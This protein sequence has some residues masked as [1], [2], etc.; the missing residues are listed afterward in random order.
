MLKKIT[1]KNFRKHTDSVFEFDDGL[2][3]MRGANEAGKSTVLEGVAYALGGVK[4]LRS[5]LAEAVTWSQP[6]NTLK[7]VLEIS[8]DGVD[9]VVSRGKSGAE[10]NYDGGCVTG[11]TEVTNFLA[12]K[13]KV[14][15]GA[16]SRLMMSSQMDIRG[17]LEA[18]PKATT[19]LIER[20]AEFDQ[21]DHLIDVMQEKLTLGSTATA[22]AQLASA[23]ETLDTANAV[24]EPDFKGL[25]QRI[26][27]AT[28]N[29]GLA[30]SYYDDAN[31]AY[32]AALKADT[33]ARSAV[34]ER[35]AAA[36]RL[37]DAEALAERSKAESIALS[38]ATVT[39]PLNP[40]ENIQA[41]MQE[42]ANLAL[43][44]TRR[45]AWKE[46]QPF[47]GS[48]GVTRYP[49]SAEMLESSIKGAQR[50]IDEARDAL[51]KGDVMHA[52]LTA[53]LMLNSCSFCGKDFS[54]V[55]EVQAKNAEVHAAIEANELKL[56]AAQRT[57]DDCTAALKDLNKV[58]TEGRGLYAAAQRYAPYLDI[59]DSV[60]P[61][62]LSWNGE[63]PTDNGDV[64]PDY[65]AMIASI[66]AQVKAFA[67]WE[68]ARE[69]VEAESA[70]ARLGIDQA[71]A[72]LDALPEADPS[73][74]GDALGEANK[75][76]RE[77]S[78]TRDEY[79]DSLRAAKNAQDRAVLD[80]E[81]TQM[82]IASAD[83]QL[84]NARAAL[85]ALT[86]NNALLKKVRTARPVIAD[87]LWNLV[88]TSVSKYFS[89]M[90]GVRS[91]VSKSSDGF[92]VD[93]RPVAVLSG[94]T[95]DI[96][97]LAIRVALVRTFLPQS[98]FLVLDEPMAGCDLTR[99][100]AMLGFLVAVGF[101]QV[102][103]VTHEDVS[104]SV[105]DHIITLGE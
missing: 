40:D 37:K 83:A 29:L 92:L 55:P 33:E 70:R 57:S 9:Y 12:A 23:Q 77:A 90:R 26:A 3:V 28:S 61:P 80:W 48:A 49:G 2:H 87:R 58:V 94:S 63:V 97:G 16:A 74:T 5:P 60:Y 6:E 95:L 99:T 53:Q 39:A 30:Q 21:I 1:L 66:R 7:V 88:L 62:F 18:G 84:V 13:L 65:D 78:D 34:R 91:V 102:L 79:K 103:L 15:A 54:E 85:R 56:R 59:D 17:A 8:I 19:E 105:A 50:N 100:E 27:S 104:E 31:D 73:A 64:Q 96:L 32:T 89:E 81:R 22:E 44:A 42:K 10:V 93:G 24:A 14:D 51:R 86:F 41:A 38:E 35:A 45:R 4:A 98:P 76:L 67:D 47:L 11:Q 68:K 46:V 52:A 36:N 71:K 82:A 25:E 72:D 75:T 101:K 20:L 43:H 69:R